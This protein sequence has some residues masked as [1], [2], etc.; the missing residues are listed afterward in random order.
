MTLWHPFWANTTYDMRD[1]KDPKGALGKG[2]G[3]HF[4]GREASRR[5][6]R[7]SPSGLAPS[8]WMSHLRQ[9]RGPR[10]Q[11]LWRGPGG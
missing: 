11:H 6:T 4:L 8:R 9:P 2:E 5:T 10:C 3:L 7:R 1:L